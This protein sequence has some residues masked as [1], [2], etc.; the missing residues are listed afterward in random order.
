[1]P[2]SITLFAIG[3]VAIQQ[4]VVDIEVR[5]NL[6][7][8]EETVIAYV[9]PLSAKA[10][11]PAE[12]REA[13]RRLWDTGF[14]EDIR[15]RTEE[16]RG[17]VRLIVE[18]DE[19]PLLRSVSIRGET[20]T[21]ADL[22]E[23]LQGRGIDLRPG[24]PFSE[25]DAAE[26]ARTLDS[27]LEDSFRVAAELEPAEGHRVDLVLEVERRVVARIGRV[28]LQGNRVLDDAALRAV[29]RLRPSDWKSWLTRRDRLRSKEL[30]AD[31]GRIRDLYRSRG[32]VHASVGLAT[33]EEIETDRVSIVI[34][35]GEGKQYELGE[36]S[37]VPGRL[38]MEEILL[39]W[40]PLSVGE[41]YDATA[42][43]RVVRR[44][45]DYYQNRG[46]ALVRVERGEQVEA[47]S[48]RVHLSLD[49]TEGPLYRVGRIEFRG[50]SRYR[51]GDVRQYLD[52]VEGERFTPRGLESSTRSLM[53]LGTF[54]AVR[55]EVELV[56]A[57]RTAEVTFQLDEVPRFEYLVGGGANGTEGATGSGQLVARS[58]LGRGGTFSAELD[59]GNRFQNFAVGYQDPFTL[60]RRFDL[61]VDFARF[62]LTF[63]D[64]TSQD[65]YDLRAR[66]SGPALRRLQHQFGLRF[67][68]FTL[69]SDLEGFVPFL[70][71]FIGERFRTHR[72]EW[73]L[74]IDRRD[75]PVFA[76]R[77]TSV[78]VRTELVGSFLGGDIELFG[79][80]GQINHVLP[81]DEGRRH[82]I[83]LSGRARAVWP[84]G[85]TERG[86]L[87]RF[88]RLFLGGENDM[89]GFAVRGVG[90]RSDGVVVGG[91][92]LVYGGAEYQYVAH[93]RFRLVGFFDLGNV[94]ATDFEGEEQPTL[95]FDA[96]AEMQILAP[97]VNV[98]F[99]FG[100][101]FN[102]D[103][104]PGESKG[105]FYLS[106]SVRF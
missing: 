80:G 16:V 36:V 73:A 74:G 95:R 47:G 86:G 101:G 62:S 27:L 5:G 103:P 52:L 84:F 35:I 88:E 7:V 9:G 14:F 90:P 93:S 72:L 57:L 50:N 40:I 99:R 21:E 34:P 102:L 75:R 76:T 81:L 18:V 55:P 48:G 49:V 104:L 78:L 59:L 39:G 41:V 29:M 63:P 96:G 8:P 56:S 12:L 24:R 94:Y 91:D 1:M 25:S 4:P 2:L 45:E 43:D 87:P 33:V 15:F 97:V 68:Q 37:V 30:D 67:A 11:S 79:A 85:A 58:V 92:R 17:G 70:T 106:L 10:P 54:R 23:E 82:L 13:F 89:R 61:A 38:L 64:E 83:A 46:Y 44:I 60:G 20:V 98:P 51:D 100:Y 53:H 3:W 65:S 31:L 19:K 66:V 32:Y 105:R 22:V 6:H 42:I 71:P 26:A 69:D 28:E 77:G